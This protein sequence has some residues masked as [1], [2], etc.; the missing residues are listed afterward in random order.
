MTKD[1]QNEWNQ[2]GE[3]LDWMAFEDRVDVLKMKY[4]GCEHYM[5]QFGVLVKM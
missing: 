2:S 1:D 4:V 3:R 5:D